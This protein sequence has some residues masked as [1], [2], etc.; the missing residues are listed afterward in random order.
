MPDGFQF[1]SIF[2]CITWG[3]VLVSQRLGTAPLYVLFTIL[4]TLAIIIILVKP[5]DGDGGKYYIIYTRGW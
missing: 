5:M 2:S 1:P 3:F 4:P